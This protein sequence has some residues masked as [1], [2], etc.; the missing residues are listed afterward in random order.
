MLSIFFVQPTCA[1]HK[2]RSIKQDPLSSGN[3]ACNS[4]NNGSKN[5]WITAFDEG[6]SIRNG[7]CGAVARQTKNISLAS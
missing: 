4:P 6:K 2:K 5:A 7:G 1:R 3:L